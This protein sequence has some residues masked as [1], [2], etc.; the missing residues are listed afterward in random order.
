VVLIWRLVWTQSACCTA[1]CT[2]AVSTGSICTFLSHAVI[3]CRRRA[4]YLCSYW[5]SRLQRAHWSESKQTHRSIWCFVTPKYPGEKNGGWCHH[6]SLSFQ[7]VS[8]EFQCQSALPPAMGGWF[9]IKESSSPEGWMYQKW[10]KV[11]ICWENP[12][13]CSS[14]KLRWKNSS[15]ASLWWSLCFISSL[16]FTVFIPAS[17]AHYL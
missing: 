7:C 16:E 13:I 9:I 17:V 4:S 3:Q 6:Q 14:I 15:C 1:A 2:N 10:A 8:T 12:V 11:I 5:V